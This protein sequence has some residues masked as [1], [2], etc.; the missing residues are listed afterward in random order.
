MIIE[1]TLG[2]LQSELPI[3][4]KHGGSFL[5]NFSFREWEWDQ[6]EEASKLK[7]EGKNMGDFVAD[8][9]GIMLTELGHWNVDQMNEEQRKQ[10][11]IHLLNCYL[12]DVFYLYV[13]LRYESMGKEL[14]LKLRCLR[15]RKEFEFVGDFESLDIA[16][17]R[18]PEPDEDETKKP[19]DTIENPELEKQ[20]A[21]EN[22]AED[23]SYLRTEVELSRGVL[24]KGDRH[25]S[26]IL[27]PCRWKVM[28]GLG[29]ED[30]NDAKMKMRMLQSSVVGIEGVSI[31]GQ[32]YFSDKMVRTLNKRDLEKLIATSTKLNAGPEMSIEAKC[33]CGTVNRY[34]IDWTYDSFF[35]LSPA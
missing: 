34:A 13:Y 33:R 7:E 5:R 25:K 2:E 19:D 35:A 30:V 1:K 27:S 23:D 3:G 6:E 17:H 20:V 24:Y 8:L 4:I 22:E 31:L 18:P 16:L 21:K 11:H 12:A 32:F 28:T 29:A 26:L 15:C 14:P 9:L 10:F